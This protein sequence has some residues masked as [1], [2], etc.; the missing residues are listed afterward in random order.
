MYEN[1]LIR[2]TFLPLVRNASG[3]VTGHHAIRDNSGIGK[4][5]QLELNLW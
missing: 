1:S 5:F 4:S 3:F 2:S